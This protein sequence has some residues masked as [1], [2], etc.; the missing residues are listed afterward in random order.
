MTGKLDGSVNLLYPVKE[1][2]APEKKALY[3]TSFSITQSGIGNFQIGLEN[4]E[5]PRKNKGY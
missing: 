3:S 5:T 2:L 4:L 1:L